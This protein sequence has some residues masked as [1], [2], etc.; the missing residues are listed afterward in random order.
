ME[1]YSSSCLVEVLTQTQAIPYEVL[2][3]YG[4]AHILKKE[5]EYNYII[6]KKYYL[7]ISK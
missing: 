3:Y 2:K 7:K 6:I 1:K 4:Y 5:L